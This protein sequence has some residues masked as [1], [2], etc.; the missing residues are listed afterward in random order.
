V[1]A[2]APIAAA[3]N[4]RTYFEQLRLH[5]R[6]MNVPA[7]DFLKD[8]S[9]ES[10]DVNRFLGG[11]VSDRPDIASAA[12]PITYAGAGDPPFLIVHGFRDGIVAPHQA[13]YLY[14]LL[15]RHDVDA[16]LLMIPGA[17]H[18]GEEIFNLQVGEALASFFH[19][20]LARAVSS[21]GAIRLDR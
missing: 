11:R 20:K 1:Q 13:E 17:G 21:S 3:T 16:Q 14:T 15:R 2:S 6:A 18:A 10:E 19:Q 4:F 9:R 8:A 7:A 12:S 5:L